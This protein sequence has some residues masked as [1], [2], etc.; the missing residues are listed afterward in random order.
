MIELLFD[1]VGN[2]QIDWKESER[3][4]KDVTEIR[5]KFQSATHR[6][7]NSMAQQPGSIGQIKL[8][9]REEKE[10]K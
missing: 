3:I 6:C 5:D 2:F 1:L 4:L 10:H 9:Y 8:R 7:T